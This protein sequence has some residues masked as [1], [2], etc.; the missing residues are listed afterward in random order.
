MLIKNCGLRPAPADLYLQY[1]IKELEF[2]K[3]K[4]IRT[5][6]KLKPVTP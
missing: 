4:A 6:K 2:C 1:F 5:N 3:K